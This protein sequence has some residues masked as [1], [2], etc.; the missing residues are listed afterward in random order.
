M[1]YLLVWNDEVIDETDDFT[2]AMYLQGEYSLAYGGV[3]T[4]SEDE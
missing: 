2:D 1:T 4:I 3:V